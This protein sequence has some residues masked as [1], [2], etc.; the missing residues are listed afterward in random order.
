MLSNEW[1]LSYLALNEEKCARFVKLYLGRRQDRQEKLD[2][3]RYSVVVIIIG[4][5]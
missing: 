5:F 4:T 1:R 2:R 3:D